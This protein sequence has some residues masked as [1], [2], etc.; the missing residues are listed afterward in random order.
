MIHTTQTLSVKYET[1]MQI[2]RLSSFCYILF[3][4]KN[5]KR[6]GRENNF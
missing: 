6:T 5:V 3:Q 4:I 2:N 1:Y